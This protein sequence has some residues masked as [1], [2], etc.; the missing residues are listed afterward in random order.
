MDTS[1]SRTLKRLC[2]D[3]RLAICRND[4]REAASLLSQLIKLVEISFLLEL[5]KMAVP[6]VLNAPSVEASKKQR[7]LQ[8][9]IAIFPK[10]VLWHIYFCRRHISCANC[11]SIRLTSTVPIRKECLKITFWSKAGSS[12]ETPPSSL[13]TRA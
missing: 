9:L 2:R 1:K 12:K 11:C 7:L 5:V 4:P 3:L 6:V 10:E 8:T 13:C